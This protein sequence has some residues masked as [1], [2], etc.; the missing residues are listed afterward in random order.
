MKVR[1]PLNKQQ[2]PPL[3]PIIWN[4]EANFSPFIYPNVLIVDINFKIGWKLNELGKKKPALQ[5]FL[6][7]FLFVTSSVTTNFGALDFFGHNWLN[8]E[9]QT[10]G[11]SA[12]HGYQESRPCWNPKSTICA[13]HFIDIFSVV[14]VT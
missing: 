12:G 8:A 6:L 13:S 11:P 2:I 3:I 14:D 5:K 9:L 4:F 10:I 1:L 7:N